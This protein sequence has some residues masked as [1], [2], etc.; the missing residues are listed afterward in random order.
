MSLL[1]RDH[2]KEIRETQWL[3]LWSTRSTRDRDLG[4]KR[5]RGYG[6]RRGTTRI[7]R[8][9]LRLVSLSIGKGH[10]KST[11]LRMRPYKGREKT[12][13]QKI[14]RT[15]RTINHKP[16]LPRQAYTPKIFT[17]CQQQKKHL[18]FVPNNKIHILRFSIFYIIDGSEW[19]LSISEQYKKIQIKI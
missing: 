17:L 13:L 3:Q 8:R 5:R 4:R 15:F 7:L 14:G 9:M 2:R 11:D 18:H 6:R 19:E 10:G 12:E 16:P 1:L